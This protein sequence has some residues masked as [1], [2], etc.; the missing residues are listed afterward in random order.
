MFTLK[1]IRKKIQEFLLNVDW[2]RQFFSQGGED[3]TLITLFNNKIKKEEPG[4]FVD[5]GAYHPYKHSNTYLFY[6]KG[7]RGINIDARPGSMEL[8]NKMRPEDINMEMGIGKISGFSTFYFLSENSTMNSFSKE[9]LIENG[10]Y[11]KV[12][13]ELRIEITTLKEVFEKKLS[14]SQKIDFL[15]IDVEGLDYDVLRSNDWEKFKPRVIVIELNCYDIFDLSENP[16]AKFLMG[17]GYK[18]V[19]KNIIMKNLASVFFVAEDFDY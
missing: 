14:C 5:V 6:T 3:I 17:L 2:S 12:K 9:S 18:I 11:E 10:F 8:F 16:S 7:W 13:K 15:S 19:S 1:S 4:F